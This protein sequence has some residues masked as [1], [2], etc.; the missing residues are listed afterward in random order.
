MRAAV[1]LLV[2]VLG[3]VAG[4][5]PGD[6]PTDPMA[7]VLAML[8]DPAPAETLEIWLGEGL[9]GRAM[10]TGHY[11]RGD[12]PVIDI[13]MPAETTGHLHAVAIDEHGWVFHL[14]PNARGPGSEVARLGRVEDGRRT[15]RV[16][17]SLRRVQEED[18]H[19]AV[20]AFRIDEAFGTTV[21]VAI[22]TPEP[23]LPAPRPV[24]EDTARF[25]D[26]LAARGPLGDAIVALRT[27]V[28]RAE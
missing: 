14:L 24:Q 7:R 10:P 18:R 20:L 16:A 25:A 9:S 2:G 6:A 12:N 4:P 23:L 26:A 27:I 28:D 22:L 5:A 13:R 19:P 1:L 8:P 17:H 15:I 3:L 21:V 11:V